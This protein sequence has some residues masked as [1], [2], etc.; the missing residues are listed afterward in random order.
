[1]ENIEK[2]PISNFKT[3]EYCK[4]M[5]FK[6]KKVEIM[7]LIGKDCPTLLFITNN[8]INEENKNLNVKIN[9]ILKKS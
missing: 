9:S 1:M 2:R 6:R 4:Q 5:S 3:W 8:R 7:C